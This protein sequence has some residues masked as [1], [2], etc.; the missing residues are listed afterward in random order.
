MAIKIS[1]ASIRHPVPALVLFTVLLVLGVISFRSIPITRAPNVDVPIVSVLV[2]QAGAAPAELETQV[3]RKIEDAI[4]SVA[5]VKHITSSVTDGAS[6]TLVELRLEVGTDRALND[7]KDAVAKIRADLPRTIDEPIIQRIDVVG[8][9][10]QTFA[11]SAPGMTVEQL[12]WFIDDTVLRALQG[13]AGPS[14]R[15]SG[16]AA[17]RARSRSIWTRTAWPRWA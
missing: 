11:A 17:C 2:T 13:V 6:T 1:G 7:V 15:W 4:A 5:G 14:A 8:Q 12:S 10:I 9:A 3:T 16:L